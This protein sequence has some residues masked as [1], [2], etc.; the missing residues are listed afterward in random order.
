MALYAGDSSGGLSVWGKAAASEAGGAVADGAV[1]VETGVKAGAGSSSA[2]GTRAG[3]G[4]GTSVA[5]YSLARVLPS[6]SK[7]WL[8]LMV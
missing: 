1:A 8:C 7:V 4:S 3:P 2:G 5:P 6:K